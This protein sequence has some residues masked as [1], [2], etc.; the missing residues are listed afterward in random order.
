MSIKLLS[1]S[2]I[3]VC[4]AF[5]MAT[6]TSVFAQKVSWVCTPQFTSVKMQSPSIIKVQ[7]GDKYG[8]IS[9]DG[10]QIAPCEYDEITKFAEGK[11]LLL[12]ANILR[13]IVDGN[14]K[15][16]PVQGNFSPNKNYPY[17]SE[18]FLAV[19]NNR[20][21]WGYIDGNGH[22]TIECSFRSA[23]P[24]SYGFASVRWKDG[25]FVH[26][27]KRGKISNLSEGFN[28]DDV[29]FAS[30][31]TDSDKGPFALVY[32]KGVFY[33]RFLN[34]AKDKS[35]AIK[36]S[37]SSIEHEMVLGRNSIIFDNAWR[38]SSI[39]DGKIKKTFENTP[40]IDSEYSGNCLVAAKKITDNR[41]Q[42]SYRDATFVLASCDSF[43]PLD[44]F[45]FAVN[46]DGQTGI[47]KLD[48]DSKIRIGLQNTMFVVN[49]MSDI[50]IA[51]S[52]ETS[53]SSSKEL[54]GSL[55]GRFGDNEYSPINKTGD[56]F[57]F[58]Y[59]PDD[60]T[61][62]KNVVLSLFYK[63]DIWDYP[64][65]VFN[66]SVVFEQA[67]SIGLPSRVTLD[68]SNSSATMTL[69]I[70]N[71][72]SQPSGPCNVYADGSFVG[73]IPSIAQNE[74]ESVKIC[75]SVDINDEDSV[76]KTIDIELKEKG[77]PSVRFKRN[78]VFER[79][80]TN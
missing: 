43:Q 64:E 63:S 53:D 38:V 34:G 12:Q 25:Y 2:R 37:L 10:G 27:D 22:L 41:F 5:L 9:I 8:L 66:V 76:S 28:D 30:S 7:K 70:T 68:S 56:N 26:I 74:K 6:Y 67:L 71:N 17:F 16:V 15:V 47:A 32:I 65:S 1:V 69:T 61:S 40:S 57:T 11:C 44:G 20:G 51:G 3:S 33:K 24:F 19:K 52:V 58:I 79:Y 45:I 78:I 77:C 31:F 55:M 42:F 39:S 60:L 62:T 73:Y 72:S 35:F 50:V 13:G 14:G 75:K 54:M 29:E 23:L 49:H 4:V 48:L 59:R 21:A 80:Y 18:G 46:K 36:G